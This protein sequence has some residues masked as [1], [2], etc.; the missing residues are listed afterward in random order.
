MHVVCYWF[1][2]HAYNIACGYTEFLKEYLGHFSVCFHLVQSISFQGKQII[3]LNII[4]DRNGFLPIHLSAMN[5]HHQIVELLLNKKIYVDQCDANMKTPL[6]YACRGAHP[7]VIQV[8]ISHGCNISHTPSCLIVAINSGS[9]KFQNILACINKLVTHFVNLPKCMLIEAVHEGMNKSGEI[10][11]S[12]LSPII[13]SNCI[14]S[15]RK[16]N[17]N[18]ST[19]LIAAVR[20]NKI[21]T[22]EVL[23][24]SGLSVWTDCC[25]SRKSALFVASE[26][27]YLAMT[28][29][30]LK[31]KC[32]INMLTSTQR[33]PLHIAVERGHCEIVELLCEKATMDDI[34]Q[35]N[36]S[37]VTPLTLAENKGR[38]RMLM[39]MIGVYQKFK[40]STYTPSVYIPRTY[41]DRMVLKYSRPRTAILKRL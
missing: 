18:L 30:I 16:S 40:Q 26:L 5:G 39:S 9:K 38:L 24:S 14:D 6:W 8:L 34:L 11:Q 2:N 31:M 3:E 33:N 17:P 22:M 29:S 15:I 36:S 12:L 41:L 20:S 4:S 19:L 27:G 37:D 21:H 35:P 32:P 7:E 25:L 1:C 10:L 13:Q 23:I 28:T